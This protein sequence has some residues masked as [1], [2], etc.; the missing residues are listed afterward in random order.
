[1]IK[2][3]ENSNLLDVKSGIICH[4]VNCIGVMGG[5]IALQICSKWPQVYKEYKSFCEGYKNPEEILGN[6]QDVVLGTDLVVANCFGQVKP[7]YECMTDYN[8]WDDILV[9]L[10]DDANFFGLDLHFPYLI[11]CGLAGGDWN[12]MFKKLYDFFSNH[13]MNAYIHK[14][15]A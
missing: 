11:G 4:Q 7:G 12:I 3:I 14:L 10:L 2:I 1:M 15:A 6:V 5:G 8:A 9:R 13:N